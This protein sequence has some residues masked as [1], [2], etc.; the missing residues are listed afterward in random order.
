MDVKKLAHLAKEIH[1]QNL[2]AGWWNDCLDN[3]LARHEVAMMLVVSE[4]S[5]A[6]E[7]DRKKLNDDHL[8]QYKMFDV[9]IADAAIRL[10]D[11][12]GAY[13][14]K[15]IDSQINVLYE[16]FV[17]DYDKLKRPVQ[18]RSAVKWSVCN[19]KAGA[20]VKLTLLSV[21][22]IAEVN[23]VNIWK[24]IDE[25]RKYNAARNDHKLSERNKENGKSY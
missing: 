3:K 21:L 9:E 1:Q 11:L 25:K 7:G 22:A 14:I 5:E 10:F 13:E 18:L 12:A 8:P 24:I 23:R 15:F 19:E 20:Q 2:D 6:M 4:L 17:N 16:N